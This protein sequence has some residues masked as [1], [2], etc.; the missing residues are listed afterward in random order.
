MAAIKVQK[1]SKV[2]GIGQRGRDLFWAL[3]D[4]TFSIDP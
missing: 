3:K 1:V 2:F 4:L